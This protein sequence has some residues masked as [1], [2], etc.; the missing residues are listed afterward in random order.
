MQ[1]SAAAG[2]DRSV[3]YDP[4]QGFYIFWDFVLGHPPIF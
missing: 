3:A 1:A 4:K 2:L